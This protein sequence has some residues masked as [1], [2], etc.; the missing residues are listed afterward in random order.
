M[1]VTIPDEDI[2]YAIG[3]LRSATMDDWKHL[4]DQNDEILRFCNQAGIEF[5]QYLPH[6][7]TQADWKKHFGLK[8]DRFVQ[9]K[10][11]YDPK[12]LLSPG[13]RI[14]TTSL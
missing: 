9:L 8:W 1:S 5:K 14:F 10:R 12:A 13:Q 3:I 7:T 11:R 6:Y 4:D 2:F